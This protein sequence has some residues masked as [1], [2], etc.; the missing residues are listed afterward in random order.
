MSTDLRV[1]VLLAGALLVGGMWYFA[2]QSKQMERVAAGA[3]APRP[4]KFDEITVLGVGTGGTFENHLR[5]GPCIGVGLG[6]ELVLVDAGRRV[7]EGL[8]AAA[9]PSGQPRLVLLTSLLPED[10]E[11]LDDLWLT[12]WH[13]RDGPLMVM[14]P[15]GTQ[16]LVDGLRAGHAE[17]ARVEAKIWDLPPNGGEIEVREISADASLERGPFHIRA[18]VLPGGPLPALAWRIEGGGRS[19]VVNGVGWGREQLAALAAHATFL[20]TE[21]LYGPSLDRLEQDAEATRHEASLHWRLADIGKL[22]RQAGV[23][24][25]ILTRLRPAPPLREGVYEGVVQKQ[26]QGPVRVLDDTQEITP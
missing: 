3:V 9:V 1:A 2:Y 4:H 5:G 6:Q 22:A 15:P 18:A 16:R 23:G 21:G 10:V 8:R 17:G 19:V 25:V 12:G 13:D 7:V 24:G 14:G 11:G 20:V 26:F